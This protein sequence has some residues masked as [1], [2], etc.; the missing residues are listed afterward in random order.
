[1]NLISAI[2]DWPVIL[3]GVVGSAFFWLILEVGQ[4]LVRK[5]GSK[6]GEDKETANLYALAA[7]EASSP[8]LVAEAR[9]VCLYGAMHYALKA[10]LVAA[11]S[12]FFAPFLD[13]FAAAGYLFSVYFLFRALS[14]VPRV[15]SMG[16]K[17]QRVERFKNACLSRP[18]LLGDKV[19]IL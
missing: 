19:D 2:T 8:A 9:F 1:M 11:M 3:Q 4:R 15:R 10:L 6:V 12:A 13:I 18:S 16:N 7:Y 17:A 14:Y 5:I